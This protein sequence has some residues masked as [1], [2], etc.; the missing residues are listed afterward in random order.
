MPKARGNAVFD[1]LIVGGGSAG[2]V[3]ANRL[4]ADGRYRVCLLEAGPRDRSPFIRMPNG[5]AML[6]RSQTYNWHYRTV[7]QKHL[8][9]RPCYAPRGRTLGGSSSI[10]LMNYVRGHAW[11]Y[12]HWASLGCTG[13]SYA[14]VLPYFRRSEHYEPAG[15]AA[16]HGT[17]GPLN[18]AALRSVNL[19]SRRFIAAARQ[20]GYPLNSDFNGAVQEG[21]GEYRVFQ[22]D[23]ERFSNARA[24][25][26]SAEQR[27]NLTVVT[28]ARVTR[29]LLEGQRAVGVRYQRK[30]RT[31]EVRAGKEV[32][33]SAGA[34]ISPQ[35]LLLSGI[36]PRTEV[37]NHGIPL[38]LE[39]PGVGRN[40][41]DHLAVLLTTREK[42]RLSVSFH[43]R[44]LPRQLWG[45]LQYLFARKGELT[46]NVGEVGG[47]LKSS[48]AE[49]IPDLQMQFMPIANAREGQ[50]LSQVFK[51]HAYTVM[52]CVL[53]PAS[54]G[55]V[56]LA[57]A[58]PLA[59]PRIDLNCAAAPRDLDTLVVGVRKLREILAQRAFDPHRA[60][61]LAPGAA[62]QSD[63]QIRD[64]LC[65]EAIPVYHSAGSCKMGVDAMAVVDPRLRVRGIASL[66]V[67]DLSIMPTLVGGNTNAPVTMIAEKAAS[68][69][70]EDAA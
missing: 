25:L 46:S 2:C 44:N 30:G 5:V 66:R 16:F 29:I 58:D 20:A 51:Y 4:S 49:S 9:D 39:L 33:L 17:D 56:T 55:S 26:R 60:E 27:P 45:L 28:G 24:Y 31:E 38:T 14:E 42:T 47:F 22:K 65:A 62:I 57:S 53:R 64:W 36:G 59:P 13:W 40:L 21:F 12:D 68:I 18:I 54:R 35:L 15:D 1:Y 43:P 50:D 11:D 23:G 7:P 48:S 37:E 6:L 10:N 52:C 63:A 61:E 69:I 8:N 70:L 41:Q 32:I 34:L 19:L 3:L 67:A